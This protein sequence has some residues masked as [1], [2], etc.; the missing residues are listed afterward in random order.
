MSGLSSDFL[1]HLPVHLQWTGT[2]TLAEYSSCRLKKSR[3]PATSAPGVTEPAMG[4]QRMSDEATAV[5][6]VLR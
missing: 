1:S 6:E 3:Q 4:A 2:S 5:P